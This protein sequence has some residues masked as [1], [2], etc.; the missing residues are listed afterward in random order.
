M[1]AFLPDSSLLNTNKS[2][3]VT[4]ITVDWAEVV[5]DYAR[6]KLV[7]YHVVPETGRVKRRVDVA[8]SASP[9]PNNATEPIQG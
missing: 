9:T 1:V 2:I 3:N 8:L 4:E 7:S 6:D 5:A